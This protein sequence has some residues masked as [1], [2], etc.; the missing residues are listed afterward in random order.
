M[1]DDELVGFA[2]G[3]PSSVLIQG[4]RLRA[5]FKDALADLLPREILTKP[6]HGFGMPFA[7]WT[8]TDPRLRALAGDSLTDLKRRDVFS[9][10]FLDDVLD[11][12]HKDRDRELCGVAWDLMMLEAW[13]QAHDAPGSAVSRAPSKALGSAA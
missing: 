7:E 8:R 5:F 10:A 3:I 12:H 1:L 9:P 4:L 6:K 11:A 13:W 2:S